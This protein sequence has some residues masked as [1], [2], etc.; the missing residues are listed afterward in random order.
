MD[1]R[2]FLKGL[3]IS[4]GAVVLGAEL[5]VV[6]AA[7]QVAAPQFV[8][9]FNPEVVAAVQRAAR[10]SWRLTYGPRAYRS[11]AVPEMWPVDLSSQKKL[12]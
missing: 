9:G 2:A 10:L 4:V 6:P 11:E 12:P 3:G 8:V 7:P 5:V 1:R